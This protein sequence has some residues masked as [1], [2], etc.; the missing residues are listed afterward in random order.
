MIEHIRTC[1][2]QHGCPFDDAE[3]IYVEMTDE[4]ADDT[5]RKVY[6][7]QTETLEDNSEKENEIFIGSKDALNSLIETLE[8]IRSRK[9]WTKE[10]RR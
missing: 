7:R 2:V 8:F 4:E 1:I 6:I 9:G 5:G 10:E 3:E